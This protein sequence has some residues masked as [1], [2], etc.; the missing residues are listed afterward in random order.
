MLK[1]CFFLYLFFLCSSIHSVSSWATDFSVS[2]A[3]GSFGGAADLI[4]CGG[5]WGS[6]EFLRQQMK[7]EIPDK[8]MDIP[9]F[10]RRLW[11]VFKVAR[12]WYQAVRISSWYGVNLLRQGGVDFCFCI[13]SPVLLFSIYHKKIDFAIPFSLLNVTITRGVTLIECSSTLLNAFFVK[14]PENQRKTP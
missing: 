11:I 8:V 6:V 7:R 12:S 4:C 1:N 2:S 3:S 10:F 14:K 9:Y 13:S 5:W